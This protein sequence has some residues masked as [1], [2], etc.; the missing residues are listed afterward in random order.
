MAL[1]DDVLADPETHEPVTRATDAQL[2]AIAAALRD[3]RAKRRDGG[4]LPDRIEGAYL[5]NE[6]RWVYPDAQG[7]PSLLVEDRLELDEPV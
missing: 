4:A 6:G 7:F 5:A 2:E 1:I 3:G